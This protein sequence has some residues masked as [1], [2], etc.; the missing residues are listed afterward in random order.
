MSEIFDTLFAKWINLGDA[1][2]ADPHE[3]GRDF[4]YA[5]AL[6]ATGK[7]ARSLNLTSQQLQIWANDGR[8]KDI[9]TRLRN[10]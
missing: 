10:G 5:L 7:V 6:Q 9:E 4:Q 3:S 2:G 8:M 1:L